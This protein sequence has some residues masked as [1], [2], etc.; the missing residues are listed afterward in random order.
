MDHEKLEQVAKA[1]CA[2]RGLRYDG[3]T[4][5]PKVKE[6]YV[7]RLHNPATRQGGELTFRERDQLHKVISGVHGVVSGLA[8]EQPGPRE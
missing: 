4:A 7:L 6:G 5:D 2:R 1:A 8:T 3:I